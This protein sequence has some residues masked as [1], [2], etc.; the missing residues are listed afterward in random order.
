M[1]YTM[2]PEL[3]AQL[4][5]LQ[6]RFDRFPAYQVGDVMSWRTRSEAFYALVNDQL[7]ETAGIKTQD[8]SLPFGEETL[9]ARWYHPADRAS[10]GA[11]L[12]IHGGGGVAADIALYH[13][14]VAKYV[15]HSGVSFLALDYTLA[16]EVTGDVQTEQALSALIWLRNNAA[17]WR[18]D[19][20]RIVL[21]GDSGGG[22]IA[23]STAILA[24]DRGIPVAGQVLI[25]PMLDHRTVEQ[26]A[27]ISPFLTITADEI[28]TAW[29]ARLPPTPRDAVLP[30]I[31]PARL[32]D[33]ARLAP[34]YLD[35]GELDLFCGENILW[36]QKLSASGVPV[37]CHLY[38]GVNHGFELLAPDA[39]IAR[40]AL[41]LRCAAI[42]RFL[43]TSPAA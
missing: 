26:S 19:P 42:G 13:K 23:A 29:R 36:A 14:I 18:I 31:S 1:T 8:V 2:D 17:R 15:A 37:E 41:Q 32:E 10:A 34:T 6:P 35:V 30:Y 43:G 25:Y 24:R 16:P 7:P 11:V 3:A 40:Q 38:P 21:M 12:F 39:A 4:A 28:Q 27:A 9:L 20:A 22:G 33:V 5:R